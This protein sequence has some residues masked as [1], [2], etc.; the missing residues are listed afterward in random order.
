MN[1]VT[2]MEKVITLRTTLSFEQIIEA[3]RIELP[4]R[5]FC[6]VSELD[7]TP[8]LVRC[9]GI[10]TL[11]YFIFV[12]QNV[13]SDNQAIPCDPCDVMR[14]SFNVIVCENGDARSVSVLSQSALGSQASLGVRM[15][16]SEVN[17]R[18]R[19]IFLHLGSHEDCS[20]NHILSLE[21][22]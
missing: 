20:Q 14:A 17:M 19:N 8:E 10:V 7:R 5:E 4:I 18:M 12:V 11:R 13:C 1:I 2:Q 15:L 22:R 16:G 3:L 9:D 21:T 6:I